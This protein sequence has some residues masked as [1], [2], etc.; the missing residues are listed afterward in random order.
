MRS[1]LPSAS[2]Q[3][4]IAEARN[5]V[6]ASIENMLD[7][8]L[9]SRAA[10]LHE[11]NTEIAEQ[12]HQVV[13]EVAGLRREADELQRVVDDAARC[14]KELGNV[15]N[16]A[17]LLHTDFL[18][19]EETMRLVREGGVS[20]SSG[21]SWSGSWSG[22]EAGDGEPGPSSAAATEATAPAADTADTADTAPEPAGKGKTKQLPS[23]SSVTKFASG[24]FV[25]NPGKAAPTTPLFTTTYAQYRN[26][27]ASSTDHHDL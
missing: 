20:G 14:V 7:R 13:L 1:G 18:V 16:W 9:L 3:R 8:E 17:E 4:Q 26:G 10:Q 11:N 22:S 21:S 23:R 6:V 15:Q 12:Q 19:L 5:A 27:T 24:I 25:G 2:T